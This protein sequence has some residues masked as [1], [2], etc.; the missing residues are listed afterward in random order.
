MGRYSI[1]HVQY[2]RF[3][4][5]VFPHNTIKLTCRI[6]IPIGGH[7]FWSDNQTMTHFFNVF[8]ATFQHILGG[9]LKDRTF[10]TKSLIKINI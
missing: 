6:F 2:I 4:P 1:G 10:Q 7:V 8:S 3:K 5:Q 9:F